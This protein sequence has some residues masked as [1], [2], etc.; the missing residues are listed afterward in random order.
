ML[1][2]LSVF[3]LGIVVMTSVINSR[4][5][6]IEKSLEVEMYKDKD[7]PQPTSLVLPKLVYFEPDD[8]II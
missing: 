2:Y 4:M 3:S 7:A 8:F 5:I 1:I 6:K